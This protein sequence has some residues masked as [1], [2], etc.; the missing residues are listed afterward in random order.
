[1]VDESEKAVADP[2]VTVV[3]VAGIVPNHAVLQSNLPSGGSS[4]AQGLQLVKTVRST[5]QLTWSHSAY[6][7]ALITQRRLW[8]MREQP[9]SAARFTLRDHT[10]LIT[11]KG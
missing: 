2:R 4:A 11:A 8:S 3:A 9:S 1:M 10:L 6:P 7:W 5:K